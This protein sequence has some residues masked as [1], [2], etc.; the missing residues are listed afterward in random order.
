MKRLE[1]LEY[2]LVFGMVILFFAGFSLAGNEIVAY[3]LVKCLILLLIASVFYLMSFIFKRVLKLDLSNK[4]AYGLGSIMTVSTFIAA[5]VYKLFG[6]FFSLTGN[7]VL[8]FLASISILIGILALL[9]MVLYKNYNFIHLTFLS[10]IFMTVFLLAFYKVNYIVLMLIIISVLLI[11]N[12]FKSKEATFEFSSFAIP[13]CAFISL[14]LF[15]VD[16]NMV[17]LFVLFVLNVVSLLSVIYNKK[18]LEHELLSIIALSG[19]LVVFSGFIYANYDNNIALIVSIGIVSILDLVLSTFR[20]IDVKAVKIVYKILN[21]G[22]L[23][24]LLLDAEF[25]TVAHLIVIMFILITSVVDA[26]AIHNDD[27]ERYF[28]PFKVMFLSCYIVSFVSQVYSSLVFGIEALIFAFIY[29]KFSKLSIKPMYAIIVGLSILLLV[30]NLSD[31]LITNVLSII[32]MLTTSFVIKNKNDDK[33]SNII[34]GFIAFMFLIISDRMNLIESLILVIVMGIY[35]YIHR[36]RK[37]IFGAS[38][39]SLGIAIET[40]LDHAIKNSDAYLILSTFM[41]VIIIGIALEILFDKDIRNKNIFACILYGFLLFDLLVSIDS[42]IAILYALIVALS[43]MLLS[44][45]KKGYTSLFYVSLVFGV[46][47]V[48]EFFGLIEGFPASLYIL[49]I[50]IAL[51]IVTSIIAYRRINSKEEVQE[52]E[53][54]INSN[55][56]YCSECG[57]KIS[58]NDTYCSECGSKVR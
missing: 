46:L 1:N 41:S 32:L 29:R 10:I 12:I 57:N 56:N 24:L 33:L 42:L 17:L 13:V 6:S 53:V 55:V 52:K 19:L 49:F 27:Y 20:I 28:L 21:I 23:V 44:I 43:L 16:N 58:K 31:S 47:Y 39:F 7:G 36:D 37:L 8:L 11:L 4:A 45:S 34:D 48:F 5:G 2:L 9:T 18:T 50:A 35:A 38:M 3:P 51:I 14:F 26:F 25:N 22:I 40:F 15:N 30:V 54:I